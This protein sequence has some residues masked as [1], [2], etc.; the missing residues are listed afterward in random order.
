LPVAE[1]AGTGELARDARVALVEAILFAAEEPL[2]AR[3]IAAAANLAHA[4]EAVHLLQRLQS[5]YERGDSAFQIAELAGGYQLYSRPEL[6]PWLI[7]LRRAGGDARLTGAARETLAI[8]AYRQPILRAEIEAIRGV[9]CTEMLRMLM[10]KGLVRIAGR[11]DTLGRP[12]LYATTK[13]F[14]QLFGLKSLRELPR[15][16]HLRAPARK[17][18]E[19]DAASDPP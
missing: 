4:D 12:V 13:K 10:E 7:R 1:P 2:S 18:V 8:I 9:Q 14:L 15:A 3:R 19:D 11:D 16:D 6:H 17:P 5:L